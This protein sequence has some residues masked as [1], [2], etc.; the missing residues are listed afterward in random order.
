MGKIFRFFC[1]NAAVGFSVDIPRNSEQLSGTRATK[2][3]DKLFTGIKLSAASNSGVIRN[4]AEFVVNMK[5]SSGF[6]K[7][8]S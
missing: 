3:H 7:N 8:L 6:Y 1:L 5:T 2:F 4:N